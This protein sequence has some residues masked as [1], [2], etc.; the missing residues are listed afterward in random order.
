M[1]YLF[2]KMNFILLL[3]SC[4]L[5]SSHAFSLIAVQA[6]HSGVWFNPEQNGHGFFLTVGEQQGQ[7]NLVISWYH[8]V[9]GEQRYVIGS[10]LFDAG[11]G[12]VTVPVQQT[13]GAGFGDSFNS[14]EVQRFDWGW[15]TVSFNTCDQGTITY[16]TARGNS[17]SVAVQ[18]LAGVGSLGCDTTE[19]EPPSVP[20]IPV[21]I[22]V[23]QPFVCNT[24]KEGL[25]QPLIDNQSEGWP[26]FDDTGEMIGF[27][28]DCDLDT[29]VVYRY[30]STDGSLKPFVPGNSSP[31]DLAFTTLIDGSSVPYLMRWERGT[32]NRFIYSVATLA[33][34]VLEGNLGFD[35]S[36]WN[37]RLLYYF[38]G[39]VGIGHSQG[40]PSKKRML[41]DDALK[42]GYAVIY[43]TGTSTDTHYNLA[44]GGRTALKVKEY[45]VS[46]YG[47]PLYTIGIGASGGG[48]QQYVYAQNHPG[49]IDAAIPQYA[50][51]D[52]ITQTIHI[53]DCELLESY[54][55]I[56][57]VDNP[58]WATWSNRSILEGL[59]AS[60]RA[61]NR[62]LLGLRGSTECVSGWRGLTPLLINP[63]WGEAENQERMQPQTLMDSVR[64]THWQDSAEIYGIRADGHAPNTIDNVGVQY[65]LQ[66]LLEEQ[67]SPSEF[68]DLNDRIGSW[69]DVADMEQEGC[70]YYPKIGCFSFSNWDPWSLR[71]QTKNNDSI[72]APRVQGDIQAMRAAYSSGMVFKGDIDIPILDWRHYLEDQLDMHNSIQSFV[73][74]KRMIS[75]DG[76]ASN[77]IIWFT[78]AR[79]ITEDDDRFNQMPEALAVMDEWMLNIL[80]HPELSVADNKPDLGIDRC[81]D[82]RGRE[83]AA[84]E[85]VWDGIID[86]KPAGACSALFETYS[87]SRIVAGAPLEGWIFKCSLQSVEQAIE[88]GMYGW[89]Q[90]DEEHIRQLK[91]I[92]PTGVCDYT[93]PDQAL[94]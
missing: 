49:L 61:Q 58:K 56:I 88:R 35:E 19:L 24:D 86:D 4:I 30:R 59:N 75:A 41:Y 13:R 36:N 76:D 21:Q 72:P 27:S 66:A 64:W 65:G 25:G 85:T 70:P 31:S 81:F 79:E 83:I 68:L 90:P 22:A 62:F 5:Y 45:F 20:V 40:D 89:W 23:Q 46:H 78:D 47:E 73:S 12:L 6:A 7:S 15:L 43:S 26:V 93:L 42:L 48:V 92:F 39:G 80:Q 69:K 37:R 11:S 17:G 44:L 87:T 33:P 9:Q 3:Q 34:G 94:I 71:N 60:D 50:Y 82:E 74:R 29:T 8:Y 28:E 67:I 2:S 1:N 63:Y 14:S 52:M 16:Q 84:G 18:R 57:D 91:V 38:Q 32:I 77:Q 10:Q 53:S 51:P 54:M 55:D